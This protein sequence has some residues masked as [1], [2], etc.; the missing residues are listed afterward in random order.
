MISVRGVPKD[1]PVEVRA[2]IA[3]D[4]EAVTRIERDSYSAPWTEQ[5]FRSLVDRPDTDALTALS[6]GVVVGFAVTWSVGDQA[7]LGNVAIAKD[8][9]N[10]GIG[11]RLVREVVVRLGRRG[12]HEVFLEVRVSNRTARRLYER[13]GFVEIGRRRNYYARPAEDAIVMRKRLRVRRPDGDPWN[14]ILPG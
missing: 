1:P 10:L 8:W 9:R 14:P 13:L 11:E 3:A 7:E 2:M 4:L 12:V 5:T 6:D